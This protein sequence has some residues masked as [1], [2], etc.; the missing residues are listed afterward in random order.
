VL[1]AGVTPGTMANSAF[2]N[3]VFSVNVTS[4]T[5]F[6]YVVNSTA[7]D[8]GTPATT[9]AFV[10]YASP[11]EIFSISGTAQGVAINPIT[12][13]AAV[14]DAN[15]IGANG[16]QIDLLSAL[17]QSIS[18]ITF[19]A[20]CTAF[21][22]PCSN[23]PELLSTADVA[24][25]P[26]TNALVSYNPKL[27]QVSVSD[28]VSRQRYAFACNHPLPCTVSPT[29][30]PAQITLSGNG[31]ATLTVQNGTTNTLTL[32]GGLAVDP[33]TNQAFVVKSGSGAIDIVDLGSVF[34]KTPI[35]TAQINELIIPSTPPPGCPQPT[36]GNPIVSGIPNTIFPQGTLTSPANDL[37][38]VQI[39]GSG[40]FSGASGSTQVRL[41]SVAIPGSNVTVNS[42]RQ[43]TVTIP[44][45]FLSAPHKYA[46]DVLTTDSSTGLTAH[47]N[48][49]DFYVVQ[50]VDM[51]KICTDSNGNPTNTQ[52]A[53]VAIADQ[54][55]NGPFSP[56]AVVSSSGCN[57][58]SVIDL[59]PSSATFGQLIG[60]PVSVGTTPQGIAISQR[61]GLA[62]V[63]NNG[64]SNAS[65]IDLTANPPAQKVPA[66]ST[67]TNPAGVAVNDATG[68]AIVANTGSN[69]IT[70]INL[71]LLFP[72]SGT[73]PPTTLTPTSIGG[74]QQPIAVAIDPD[75]GTNNQGIAVVTALQLV[76]GAAPQ[77]AL[78]VVE[79]GL[80]TPTL[81]TT[82][83]SGSVTATPT[84]IVFD[85]TVFTGTA[86]N[87]EFYANSSGSNVITA[88]N[89]DSGGGSSVNVG[90]NPTSLA[91]NPQTG[92][93]LTSNS[94]SNTIS[95]VD[96]LSNP[97]KTRQTFGIP[98]SATFGVA[99]DQF[100]NLAVI[101]DQ[102]HNRVLLFPMPN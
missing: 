25:Q 102:A 1:I 31:T 84:G 50:A 66:V 79:I 67:G 49:T 53:S 18:S 81:S 24:W 2:F 8:T 36:A 12:N 69:T 61:Y 77:G 4:S 74:I 10:F 52:P 30:D 51:S 54:L 38:G 68:A 15:A 88:F 85:P 95:I 33:V 27:N 90:I 47:S 17:D 64:S 42:Q 39:F 32:F 71:G 20:T 86:N 60:N 44:K 65:V 28:P 29:I 34:T 97:F 80:Q 45:S 13:T 26:Y 43:M 76:S 16:P 94:A 23:A 59:N 70:M 48:A 56:I 55:A 21:T 82:I 58:I 75:R 62:V 72:P 73:T 6:T 11:D 100:T 40:F 5:T 101:V 19:F 14:A 57:T 98:G 83:P 35:K 92:A 93:I 41:D 96:T 87:G 7:S 3:G 89:P 99:I 91:L 37:C 78:A 22:T 63:A 9:G 46:L